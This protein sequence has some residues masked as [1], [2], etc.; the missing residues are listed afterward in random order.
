[1]KKLIISFIVLIVLN[2]NLSLSSFKTDPIKFEELSESSRPISIKYILGTNSQTG[3]IVGFFNHDTLE[4]EVEVKRGT[5]LKSTDEQIQ[6][7]IIANNYFSPF[8]I[9]AFNSCHAEWIALK[10]EPFYTFKLPPLQLTEVSLNALCAE[11][12]KNPPTSAN[13][14]YVVAQ[15]NHIDEI[16]KLFNG[17]DIINNEIVP[18]IEKAIVERDGANLILN[19]NLTDREIIIFSNLS[20]GMFLNFNTL[21]YAVWAIT[22]SLDKNDMR[23]KLRE[24]SGLSDS[25]DF[26]VQ[27]E[28]TKIILE[29]AQLNSYA[30]KF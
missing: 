5:L 25:P 19:R 10:S 13:N 27:I 18:Q 16:E 7:M 12:H 1:M 8:D 20:D 30:D 26:D 17:V 28:M 4:L 21:N 3:L 22:D 29:E 9:I 15:S 14:K 11:L 23:S 24:W 2:I 6:S